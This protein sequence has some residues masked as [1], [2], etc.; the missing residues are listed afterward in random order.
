M[1]TQESKALVLAI[2]QLSHSVNFANDCLRCR[3]TLVLFHSCVNS[4]VESHN[5]GLLQILRAKQSE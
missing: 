4:Y 2:E 1:P 5:Q 3:N